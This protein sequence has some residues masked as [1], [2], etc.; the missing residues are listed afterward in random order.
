MTAAT[1]PSSFLER[2]LRGDAGVK[3]HRN[4]P[5]GVCERDMLDLLL[6]RYTSIRRGTIADRWTRAEHVASDLGHR[7]KGIT[8]VADFI[9]ADKYPGFP[10]GAALAFHGH[11]V[12]VSRSDWLSELRD[13]TK[14][15]ACKRY[16]HY[17][18]LVVPSPD[19]VKPEELPSDW[20]LLVRSGDKLR[21]KISAPRL[22]P[23]P[24]PTDFAISLMAAAARTA[25][26]DPLR[27][28][29]PTVFDMGQDPPR[30]AFCG[31]S[32]PCQL[33]QPRRSSREEHP[34]YE[35]R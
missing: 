30:C 4:A 2:R 6:D 9:A 32:S 12:K 35:W 19:I 25:Y 33:H 15:Q 21:A 8:K 7:R 20:G 10:Y 3:T 17:W 22:T 1:P 23:E 18:W 5:A 13:L 14:A 29:A 34:H 24:M 27:R 28:D 16:M 11:E 26:R 31:E